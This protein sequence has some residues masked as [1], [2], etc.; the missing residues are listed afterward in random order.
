MLSITLNEKGKESLIYSLERVS[1]PLLGHRKIGSQ[2]SQAIF[3][4][5]YFNASLKIARHVIFF[6]LANSRKFEE[7]ES[8]N[9]NI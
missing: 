9:N 1:A 7:A 6:E 2:A 4:I 3:A 8:S 5:F